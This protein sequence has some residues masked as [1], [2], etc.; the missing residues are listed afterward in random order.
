MEFNTITTG[1]KVTGNDAKDYVLKLNNNVYGQ[2][3]AGW[4]WNKFLEDKLI[5]KVDFTKSKYD[6]C[7]HYKNKFVYILY[8]DDSILAGP[9]KN[10]INQIMQWVTIIN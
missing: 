4:A 1:F 8:T 2:K 9:D 7:V 10:K 5:N 6:E 3:Q